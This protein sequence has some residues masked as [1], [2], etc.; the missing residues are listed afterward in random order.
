MLP[1]TIAAQSNVNTEKEI[2]ISLDYARSGLVEDAKR[3]LI[4]LLH[5]DMD[6]NLNAKIRYALGTICFYEN[7]LNCLTYHWEIII[8]EFPNSPEA[9]VIKQ[10][11]DAFGFFIDESLHKYYD[12]I[13]FENELE[14]S[15]KFWEYIKPDYKMSWETIRDPNIALEFLK[16]LS[17]K[18]E[19]D[20]SKRAILL[21]EQFR[22][23][24][25]QCANWSNLYSSEYKSSPSQYKN[26]DKEKSRLIDIAILKSDS[27]KYIGGAKSYYIRSQ[28]YL[29]VLKSGS[30]FLSSE[31]K[32][33][34]EAIPFFENVLEATA[35][36]FTNPYK[37]FA[38]LW[39][40]EYYKKNEK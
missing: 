5:D 24:S 33:K 13:N 38:S 34:K 23:Y 4:A 37:I 2:E 10:I 40:S 15:R 22:I 18:Y 9:E 30:K 16:N 35:E 8:R 26:E 31:I 12:D 39:L 27:L 11:N 19:N 32:L 3:G 6:N 1:L 7:D 28:F 29:G 17:V 36:D 25:G 21:Y 14:T 20:N